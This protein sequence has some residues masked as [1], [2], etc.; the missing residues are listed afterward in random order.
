MAKGQIT[1]VI[2]AG[3]KLVIAEVV[4]VNPPHPA[5]FDEVKMQ[6]AQT[7]AQRE[8]TALAEEKSKKLKELLKTNGG[9]LQ[10]AAKSLGLHVKTADFFSRAGAAEGIG[11]G[12]ALARSLRQTRWYADR[13]DGHRRPD[14]HG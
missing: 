14:H 1:D 6:V 2:Q 5:E 8:G 3:N 12:Q 7:Y 4:S 11:P 13:P 10:A 9:D